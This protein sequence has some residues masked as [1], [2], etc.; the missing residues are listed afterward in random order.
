[1]RTLKLSLFLVYL[2]SIALAL[3][4]CIS[5]LSSPGKENQ[6]NQEAADLNAKL[7]LYY[8]Q[9]NHTARAKQKILLAQR[10]A[11]HHTSVWYVQ[12]YLSEKT[13]NYQLAEKAYLHA[14]ALAPRHGAAHNN[15]GTFLC[16]QGNYQAAIKQFLLAVEDPDYLY[17]GKAY[18]N[19]GIC[20]Q[21]IPDPIQAKKFFQKASS[22]GS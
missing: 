16:R 13:G 11:P 3:S 21:K 18:Q 22:Y 1:M 10:Q 6:E 7:A 8:L 14:I 17:V 20:A 9:M 4:G 12:G 2:S 5:H 15:Y 19:A